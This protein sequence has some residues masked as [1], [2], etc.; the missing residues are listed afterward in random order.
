MNIDKSGKHIFSEGNYYNFKSW[1]NTTTV[2][3]ELYYLKT[4]LF[5]RRS[6]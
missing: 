5:T 4:D 6:Q 2:E 3:L 1:L